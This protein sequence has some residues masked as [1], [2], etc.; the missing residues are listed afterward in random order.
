MG[1]SSY[2]PPAGSH[3]KPLYI[4][5]SGNEEDVTG[6]TKA[7]GADSNVNTL[8]DFSADG[9]LS[10]YETSS[11]TTD[12]IGGAGTVQS[13]T[14]TVT[15]MGPYVMVNIPDISISAGVGGWSSTVFDTDLTIKGETTANFAVDGTHTYLVNGQNNGTRE[16]V[17]V[18]IADDTGKI[19]FTNISANWEGDVGI[20]ATVVVYKTV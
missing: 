19:T 6:I 16:E 3:P 10:L 14:F 11:F 2:T 5:D 9:T 4:V 7:S 20:D 13:A 15:R 1:D 18:D 12:L 17:V 8:P